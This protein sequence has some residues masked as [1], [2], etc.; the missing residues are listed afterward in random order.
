[1][2]KQEKCVTFPVVR[3]AK[4]PAHRIPAR[5]VFEEDHTARL[6][7]KV[8]LDVARIRVDDELFWL[9]YEHPEPIPA[10][11][12]APDLMEHISRAVARVWELRKE[13]V[14]EVL[15]ASMTLVKGSPGR[16]R[17]CLP[18]QATCWSGLPDSLW[19]YVKP[20]DWGDHAAAEG[21]R[22][23]CR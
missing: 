4:A 11:F 20:T 15:D 17:D 22:K 7:L 8:R 13:M 18:T 23:R 14:Y 12:P 1:M 6:W 10:K 21:G 9:Y 5:S 3:L 16:F 2:K 19:P